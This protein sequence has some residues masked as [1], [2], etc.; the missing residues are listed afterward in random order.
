MR[1]GN[2]RKRQDW[3]TRG[4]ITVEA[5]IVVPIVLFCIFWMMEGGIDLYLE[6]AEHFEKQKMWE[7]FK[8]AEKFRN[9]DLLEEFL[10]QEG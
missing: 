6:T 7:N 3:T 2:R 9:L 10:G 8:P 4:S 5:A 1:D